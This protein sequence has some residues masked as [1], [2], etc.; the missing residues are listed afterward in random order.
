MGGTWMKVGAAILMV[1]M[2]VLWFP[3]MRDLLKNSP[4]AS[5][6]DWLGALLPLALVIGFVALL[7]ALV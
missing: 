2:V 1:M 6:R 5:G 3:R 7:M 4:S